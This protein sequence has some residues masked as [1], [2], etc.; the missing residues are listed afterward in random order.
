MCVCMCVCVCVCACA[1]VCVCVCVF[2]TATM[3]SATV[4]LGIVAGIGGL[5]MFTLLGLIF[6]KKRKAADEAER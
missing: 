3:S 1:Y 6:W 5:I 2:S 4:Y